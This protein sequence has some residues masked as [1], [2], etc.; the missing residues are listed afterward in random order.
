MTRILSRLPWLIVAMA[1]CGLLVYGFWPAAVEVD[2]V[3]VTQG[4]I[5][6]TVDDDGETRIREKYVV[7]APVSGKMLRIRLHPGDSVSQGVTELARIYPEDPDLLDART[8][9]E[10]E[11]RVKA[12]EATLQQARA[13][14]R[15]A[16]EALELA[17]HEYERARQLIQTRAI[18]RSDFDSLEHRQHIAEAD[19]QTADFAVQVAA[20]ELE[21]NSAALSRFDHRDEM[22][23]DPVTLVAP[24]SGQVL[25]VFHEEARGVAPGTS[26][27]EIGDPRDLEIE[28]DVLSTEAVRIE[29]GDRVLIEH[30]GGKTGLEAVVR[31]V[32]PAAFLKISALGVEEKRV[33][34]IADF[35]QDQALRGSLGDGFRIE[36][37]IVVH[38][39]PA[40]SL[41]LASG[42]LF[43]ERDAWYVYRVRGDVAEKT[44]VTPGASNGSETE[45]C[46]GLAV[47]DVVVLHPTEQ[48]RA[49]VR[50]KPDR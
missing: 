35:V 41:K 44:P 15:R 21:M 4:S 45:I 37:R 31:L 27:L 39:T 19:V 29:P 5:D 16:R 24:V 28:I 20:F 6:V 34:V 22:T 14:A 8:R 32:E 11:A 47:G 25:Q 10:Y 49:G 30:W 42:C 26:L 13:V 46:E 43:R 36:A 7:S 38:S 12:A 50:V 3:P 17:N 40:D 33:N 9:A 18:S 48:V 2:V 23:A 1:G